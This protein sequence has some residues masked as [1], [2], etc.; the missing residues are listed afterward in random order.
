MADFAPGQVLAEARAKAAAAAS[1]KKATGEYKVT[2]QG[3]DG[4]IV[5][6]ASSPISESRTA[7]YDG[8]NIV[9]LPTDLYSYRN[10][11]GRKFGINGKL[12]SRTDGEAE[13][14]AYILNCIRRWILPDFGNS[15]ATPPILKLSAYRNNNI[16]DLNCIIRSYA[17]DFVDDVDYVWTVKEPMPV[18]GVLRMELDEIYSAAD[19]TNKKW[20]INTDQDVAPKSV[21]VTGSGSIGVS[22]S[23]SVYYNFGYKDKYKFPGVATGLPGGLPSIG[24]ILNSA[25]SAVNKAAGGMI[26]SMGDVNSA[27]GANPVNTS[28]IEAAANTASSSVI[29]DVTKISNPLTDGTMQQAYSLMPMQ[30]PPGFL[31]EA[32]GAAA[33]A[34]ADLPGLVQNIQPPKIPLED[35]GA[36][37][38]GALQGFQS[39][40][41]NAAGFGRLRAFFPPPKVTT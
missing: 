26:P 23:T 40:G 10:T 27:I 31:N 36:G 28:A 22:T 18:I 29:A 8:Y 11:S 21:K 24:S 20:K 13:V 14:N 7:N 15:G 16:K 32:T 35:A 4:V 39:E 2:I 25:M 1:A 6:E 3:P 37:F 5:F 34:F 30:P 17:W 33:G 38:D 19:I 9:H 12:V 41:G